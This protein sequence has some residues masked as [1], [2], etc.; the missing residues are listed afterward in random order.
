[1]KFAAIIYTTIVLLTGCNGPQSQTDKLEILAILNNERHA[2]YTNDAALFLSEFSDST[3]QIKKGAV[4]YLAK[5]LSKIQI[6]EY[7]N[8]SKIVRWDDLQPPIIQFSKDHTMAYAIIKKRVVTMPANMTGK[9]DT[10]IYAWVSI[11]N[12]T[13]D[14]WKLVCNVSTEK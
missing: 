14:Q 12:K 9:E 1:M 2:H 11:F 7:F 4:K 6:T 8:S 3:Y 10:T 13:T 5:D